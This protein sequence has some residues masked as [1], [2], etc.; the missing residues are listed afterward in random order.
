MDRGAWWTTGVTESDMT[1]HRR[2]LQEKTTG[3]GDRRNSWRCGG[4]LKGSY[5]VGGI[6]LSFLPFFLPRM[7]VEFQKSVFKIEV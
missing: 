4:G 1:E 3:L 5:L 7:Y 6:W 2:E